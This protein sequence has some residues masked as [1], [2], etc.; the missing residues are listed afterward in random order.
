MRAS[1]LSRPALSEHAASDSAPT[2]DGGADAAVQALR[3][4]RGAAL[5]RRPRRGRPDCVA[6]E[7]PVALVYNGVSHAVMLATPRDLEDFAL[8]FSLSEGD[9]RARRRARTTCA[10]QTL[11]E[12]IERAPA[13]SGRAR[14]TR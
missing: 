12:G 13:H 14:R 9:H 10:A 8:G 3:G 4:A 7:V 11:L 5:A 6:E 1:R 2:E